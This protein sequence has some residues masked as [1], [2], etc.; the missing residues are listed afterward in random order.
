MISKNTNELSEPTENKRRTNSELKYTSVAKTKS[1]IT[2]HSKTKATCEPTRLGGN[3]REGRS[4][5]RQAIGDE[6]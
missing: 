6:T 5:W 1:T 4:F 3:W 2:N